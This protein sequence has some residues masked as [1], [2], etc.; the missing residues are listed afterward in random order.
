[1]THPA[2]AVNNTNVVLAHI[3]RINNQSLGCTYLCG[4]RPQNRIKGFAGRSLEQRVVGTATAKNI[5]RGISRIRNEL[6]GLPGAVGLHTVACLNVWLTTHQT[7]I[8]EP[9]L[10]AR[11]LEG[12]SIG[13]AHVIAVTVEGI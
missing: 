2:I 4:T 6:I 8:V 13:C 1:M 7:G 12:M 3:T 9:I 5:Q 10:W 11:H